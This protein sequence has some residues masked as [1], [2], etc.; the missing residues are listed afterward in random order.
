MPLPPALQVANCRSRFS[1]D[2][3]EGRAILLYSQYPNG[4][5]DPTSIHGGCPVLNGTKASIITILSEMVAIE[6]YVWNDDRTQPFLSFVTFS[7]LTVCSQ[8]LDMGTMNKSCMYITKVYAKN[9]FFL[10]LTCCFF[11]SVSCP[12]RQSAPRD[13][14]PGC[15]KNPRKFDRAFFV[16]EFGCEKFCYTVNLKRLYLM[17]CTFCLC[18]QISRGPPTR[19]GEPGPRS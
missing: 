5:K 14:T 7:Q 15:P 13:G 17:H 10:S 16:C 19:H 3:R 1:I 2:P 12:F 4:E 11:P 6:A 9:V 8:L 18:F